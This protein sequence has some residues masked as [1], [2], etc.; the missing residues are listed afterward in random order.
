[1]NTIPQTRIGAVGAISHTAVAVLA[2]GAGLAIATWAVGL[3]GLAATPSEPFVSRVAA[4]GAVTLLVVGVI[5][6]LCRLWDRAPLASIGLT[7]IRADASG[8]LLGLVVVLCPAVLI[9][10]LL[11][12]VGA[13]DWR[14]ISP[15]S[16]AVF[17]MTNTVVA[18]LFEAIPEEIS[19]RG[20]ALTALRRHFRNPA[21]TALNI[22]A[23]LLV[24][25]VAVNLEALLQN[26]AGNPNVAFTLAPGGEDAF[27][28]YAMLTGFGWMLVA[29][30]DA[31]GAG[32]VW[33]C[34][35]AHIAFLT[36]NRTVLGQAGGVDIQLGEIA[37]LVF[38]AG[39]LVAAGITFS[40]LVSRR[41][42][43]APER[44]AMP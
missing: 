39:Y 31:T 9:L 38:F 17:L 3:L 35:G 5:V 24:P 7:G 30:R 23:F 13:A 10:G 42:K 14:E 26:L 37:T 2:M 12:A 11:T 40:M 15:S 1:M 4:G 8:F 28:Y 43:R 21:A 29:A 20:Y 6:L 25:L 36:V 32:T 19:I 22:V 34:I 18:L 27:F 33:T 16:L 44:P 41:R